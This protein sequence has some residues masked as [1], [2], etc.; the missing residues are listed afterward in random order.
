M[1]GN[2]RE[3]PS[4]C[5]FPQ[6]LR[7]SANRCPPNDAANCR[8]ASTPTPFC[9]DGATVFGGL[10]LLICFKVGFLAAVATILRVHMNG[11]VWLAPPCSTWVWMSR[12]STGRSED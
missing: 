10:A 2:I 5:P 8:I 6:P 11:L 7:G 9:F 4:R 12:H 1:A 3:I